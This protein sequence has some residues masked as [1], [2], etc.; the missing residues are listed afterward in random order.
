M[1][2]SYEAEQPTPLALWTSRVAVFSACVL[3]SGLM[4]H[5]LFS[6][7]TPVMLNL[8]GFGFAGA[9]LALILAAV[10]SLVMWFRGGEGAARI[11]FGS[12]IA[13]GVLAW[14]AS[15]IPTMMSLPSIN[16][17][18]THPEQPPPFVRV[19]RQRPEGANSTQYPGEA[20]ATIQKVA[21]PDLKPLIIRRSVNETF[22]VAVQ[23]I[24]RLEMEIVREAQPG[25]SEQQPGYIEAIDSTLILGFRDDVVVR[26]Y[27]TENAARIDVRSA[28][29]YGKHDFGRNAKRVRR[30]LKEIV[31]R[32]EATVIGVKPK[33]AVAEPKLEQKP[34]VKRKV[35]RKRRA[36]RRTKRYRRKRDYRRHLRS[37][38]FFQ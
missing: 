19:T 4:L 17:V 24:R 30:V 31:A 27:G 7:P 29:R 5:R 3:L 26:V 8:V 37:Q 16:D 22:E 38:G 18:T 11:V 34:V 13:L 6:M 10:A 28:S 14:P 20:F 35:K 9:V 2:N 1:R 36:K 33:K 21:Y 12:L 23:A 15:A 25:K 32:L